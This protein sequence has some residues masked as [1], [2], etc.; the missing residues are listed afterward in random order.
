MRTGPIHAFLPNVTI[1]RPHSRRQRAANGGPPDPERSQLQMRPERSGSRS[2]R[3]AQRCKF[4]SLKSQPVG[5]APRTARPAESR[6]PAIRRYRALNSPAG[7]GRPGCRAGPPRW[8]YAQELPAVLVE[9]LRRRRAWRIRTPAPGA[10]SERGAACGA[11][12]EAFGRRLRHRRRRRCRRCAG[13]LR[14]SSVRLAAAE[15][16]RGQPLQQRLAPL[17]G[18]LLRTSSPR[19]ARISFCAGTGSSS[20]RGIRGARAAG[21]PAAAE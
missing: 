5:A 6:D 13:Q 8:G 12:G 7:A 11:S 3:N 21:A 9:T 18:M 16:D 14:S 20:I 17:S 10:S 19:R 2:M 15:A 4:Q 1:F